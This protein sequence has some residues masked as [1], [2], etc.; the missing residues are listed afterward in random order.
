[1]ARRQFQSISNGS[2]LALAVDV[3]LLCE[4]IHSVITYLINENDPLS[5]LAE[6]RLDVKLLFRTCDL[7]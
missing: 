5:Y 6:N 3:S 1:M 7:R 2:I 4:V